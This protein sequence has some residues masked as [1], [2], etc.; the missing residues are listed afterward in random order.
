MLRHGHSQRNSA[1]EV[2]FAVFHQ[3]YSTNT[4]PS[5]ERAQPFRF[6]CH[7]GDINTL[8]GNIAWMR[9]N[10]LPGTREPALELA[11]DRR[12]SEWPWRHRLRDTQPG[13][14]FGVGAPAQV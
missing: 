12:R 7:N 3:R 11:T 1:F 9:C 4:T 5:W 14:R 6:L 13:A 2:A 10:R 8:D